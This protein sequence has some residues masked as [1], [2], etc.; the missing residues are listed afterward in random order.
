SPMRTSAVSTRSRRSA[1]TSPSR[2]AMQNPRLQLGPVLRDL[3]RK[4]GLTLQDLS[5]RT[6]LASS[7][8]SKIENNLISPTYDSILKLADGLGID[9]AQLFDPRSIQM[10]LGRRSVTRDGHGASYK[11]DQYDYEML[12]TDLSQ[13]KFFPIVATIKANAVEDFPKLPRHAS[14]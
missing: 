12:C 6:G 1:N 9:I 7:T 8:L 2:P 10:S 13:K 11:T 5:E 4:G 3:R 14:E